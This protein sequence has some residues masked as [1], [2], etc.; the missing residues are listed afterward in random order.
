VSIGD[1]LAEAR[2]Q[3]GLTVTQV[4]QRTR[5]RETIIRG[6]EQDDFSACGGDFYARGHIRSVAAVV[7]ADPDPL[8]R[9]YDEAHGAPE[10]IR[11]ADVFEPSK[12]IR[13]RERR[14]LNWSVAMILAL[15]IVVGYGAYH[16]A[17]ASSSPHG[18]GNAAAGAP[19]AP[20][21]SRSPAPS[22]SPSPSPSP[23]QSASVTSSRVVIQVSAVEDCWVYLTDSQG[24]TIYSG[25]ISAGSS[26][27][28]KERRAVTL[29][30]GNPAGVVLLVNG[31]KQS[32]GSNQPVTLSIGPAQ[33][34][35]GL[36]ARTAVNGASAPVP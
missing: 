12:P 20:A 22:A 30:L 5:I 18:G 3:A 10:A 23:S 6:I 2:R 34:V 14:S 21:R 1:T 24:N 35:S 13:I 8:I 15:L 4:S 11:A 25:V 36:A 29:R 31:K 33:K 17:S 28:W 27:T 9:E 16:L 32:P 7:G 26:Q 19:P